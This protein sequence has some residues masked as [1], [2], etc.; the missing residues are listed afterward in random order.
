[1][2]WGVMR[3]S[4][5][6]FFIWALYNAKKISIFIINKLIGWRIKYYLWCIHYFN[7]IIKLKQLISII[8]PF[9][10]QNRV[11]L[12]INSWRI[13]KSYSSITF[14]NIIPISSSENNIVLQFPCHLLPFS[15]KCS[16]LN[17][18]KLLKILKY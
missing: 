6:G 8:K 9:N 2:L 16:T 4:I 10:N 11:N 13:L 15:A 5:C 14:V 17:T 3:I 1:M 12:Q 7:A 18:L